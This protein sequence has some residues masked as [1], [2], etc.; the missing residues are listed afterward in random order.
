M[1]PMP[2]LSSLTS[3]PLT[4]VAVVAVAVLVGLG[5]L[6]GEALL[7]FLTG[8]LLRSPLPEGAPEETLP[9]DVDQP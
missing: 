4:L 3:Q 2:S 5:R 1:P 7:T 9:E 8:L 6:E